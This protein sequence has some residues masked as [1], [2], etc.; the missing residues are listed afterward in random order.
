[1]DKNLSSF[2]QDSVVESRDV[3]A[4]NM[5][6]HRGQLQVRVRDRLRLRRDV[7]PVH[8]QERVRHEQWRPRSL[9]WQRQMCQLTRKLRMRLPGRI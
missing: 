9:S 5:Y 4:R 7:A 2:K 6:E 8:R 1:M 3:S